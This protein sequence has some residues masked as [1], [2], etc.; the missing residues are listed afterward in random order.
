MRAK[1]II[2]VSNMNTV[3]NGCIFGMVNHRLYKKNQLFNKTK[4]KNEKKG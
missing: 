1:E 2:Y 4:K 3:E